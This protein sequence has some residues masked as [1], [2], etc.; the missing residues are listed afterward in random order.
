MS[1][2]SPRER[3]SVKNAEWRTVIRNKSK[4]KETGS[5]KS[6]ESPAMKSALPDPGHEY[7]ELVLEVTPT[8]F[9][10]TESESP[11]MLAVTP[12]PR[13]ATFEL[14]PMIAEDDVMPIQPRNK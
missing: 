7:S 13:I 2:G 6:L 11:T 1:P 12:K 10:T 4:G 9:A 5:Y 8:G 14:R 3:K